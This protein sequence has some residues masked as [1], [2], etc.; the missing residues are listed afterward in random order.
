MRDIRK[1]NIKERLVEN[2]NKL[3]NTNIQLN[4][5]GYSRIA[6]IMRGLV[7]TVKT[8][9]LITAENPGGI[10]DDVKSNKEANKKL[11]KELG[12]RGYGYTKVK[13]KYG[14]FE[15]SFFVPNIQKENL[16]KLGREFGQESVIYGEKVKDGLYDGFVFQFIYCDYRYGKVDGERYIFVNRD[17]E[18][19]YYTEVKGRKFQIPFFDDNYEDVKFEKGS[20]VYKLKNI[21]NI[22]EALIKEIEMSNDRNFEAKRTGK[23]KW[24]SRGYMKELVNKLYDM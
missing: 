9:G 14:Y 24:I 23:S 19:D 20:G 12:I 15:N 13:G 8:V 3:N 22:S 7:P 10:D 6:N 1:R 17:N 16:L 4:E 18:D 2:F 5:S 11:E 21:D